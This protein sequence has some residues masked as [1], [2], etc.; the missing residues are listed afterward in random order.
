MKVGWLGIMLNIIGLPLPS[1]TVNFSRMDS[2][3]PFFY[4]WLSN[5]S[6]YDV[7]GLFEF[8]YDIFN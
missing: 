1:Q 3:S 7:F 2:F 8:L 5:M 6:Y 4:S